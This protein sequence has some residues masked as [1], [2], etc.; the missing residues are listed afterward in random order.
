MENRIESLSG[1]EG[2]YTGN[3]NSRIRDYTADA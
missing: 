3:I 1:K 2:T